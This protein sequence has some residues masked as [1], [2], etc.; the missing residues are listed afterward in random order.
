MSNISQNADVFCQL[1]H[2]KAGASIGTYLDTRVFLNITQ[3]ALESLIYSLEP[4]IS[5]YGADALA[6]AC[7]KLMTA[8][9]R[10]V[11]GKKPDS[12]WVSA[13]SPLKRWS[14]TCTHCTRVKRFLN[15][16]PDPVLRLERIGAPS[17]KH[18]EQ[19]L[20]SSARTIATYD[21]I[22]STPQGLTVSATLYSHCSVR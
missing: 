11:L 16:N 21:M 1:L 2:I 12:D 9:V 15:S 20:N 7:Q 8:W 3:P 22:R 4:L 19:Q 6:P 14:C 13:L 18:L 5:K 17:R 10:T